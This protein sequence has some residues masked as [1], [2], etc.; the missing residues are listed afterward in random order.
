VI[1]Y[2]E[3]EPATMSNEMPEPWELVRRAIASGRVSPGERTD[4]DASTWTVR[5][6]DGTL[7]AHEVNADGTLGTLN[8]P[9][10]EDPAEG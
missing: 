3:R 2:I 4:G 1:S 5:Q 7:V 10:W 9:A 6:P 8:I